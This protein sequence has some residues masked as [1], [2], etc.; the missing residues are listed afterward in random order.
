MSKVLATSH[1]RDRTD[2]G[3]DVGSS[4]TIADAVHLTRR[5]DWRFLLPASHLG[6][7]AYIGPGK[8]LLL[9]ALTQFCDRL[10]LP[11][12]QPVACGSADL[13]VAQAIG[14]GPL[15]SALDA[16]APGGLV[17][18]ELSPLL[19]VFAPEWRHLARLGLEPLNTFWHY[20]DFERCELITPLTSP[21]PLA[22]LAAR[23]LR[24]TNRRTLLR[25][26]RWFTAAPSLWRVLP[27]V[28]VIARKQ[29]PPWR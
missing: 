17:Y 28:S 7:V 6:Q 15:T 10:S 1:G 18:W 16:L 3:T 21:A 11:F 14:R 20:P 9:P 4:V 27:S 24:G 19:G 25:A 12:K 2:T 8:G 29:E 5:L 26:S 22:W 23:K 13:L